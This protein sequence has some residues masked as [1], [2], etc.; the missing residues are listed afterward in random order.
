[1][2]LLALAALAIL[3][4]SPMAAAQGVR[5]TPDATE[6][7]LRRTPL[8]AE[9]PACIGASAKMCQTAVPNASLTHVS[10]CMAA[11]SE[12]WAAR[13]EAALAEMEG[14]AARLDAAFEQGPMADKVPFRLVEDLA[15]QQKQWAEWR[16]IR[17][18]VEAMLRRGTPY[19]STAAGTCTMRRIGEQALF[20][21]Q[22]V[23]Y[24]RTR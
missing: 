13:M 21:E 1:M 23:A 19:T 24:A 6:E 14:E 8:P 10:L 9:K 12:Y 4:T 11:E 7:C 15:L 22:S 18:A 2:K 16:E 3:S 20:L 5:F 17:C